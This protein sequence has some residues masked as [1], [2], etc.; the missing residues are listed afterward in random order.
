MNV[1]FRSLLIL[2]V[3]GFD[4]QSVDMTKLFTW[5][6]EMSVNEICSVRNLTVILTFILVRD[7]KVK[8]CIKIKIYKFIFL[9][10]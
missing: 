6:M 9:K 1:E 8:Y 4:K 10:F 7:K 3:N 5:K 2:S